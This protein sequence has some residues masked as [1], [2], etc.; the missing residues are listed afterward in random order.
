MNAD[1]A[2]I[3]AGLVPV[4]IVESLLPV[5]DIWLALG[6]R[7]WIVVMLNDPM[8]VFLAVSCI[9]VVVSYSA[10]RVPTPI[11]WRSVG[12]FGMIAGLSTFVAATAAI[13]A[14]AIS[15][16]DIADLPT[17]VFDQALF[18]ELI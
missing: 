18:L 8:P 5:R 13:Y 10:A 15:R 12:R 16:S 2:A 11:N 7:V 6:I 9:A 1:Q 14:S 3:L 17:F 4:M